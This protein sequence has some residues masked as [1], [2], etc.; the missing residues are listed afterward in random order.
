MFFEFD[1]HGSILLPFFR[2]WDF[3]LV[4]SRRHPV[5]MGPH[6]RVTNVGHYEGPY[7]NQFTSQHTLVLGL[8]DLFIITHCTGTLFI[9]Y[10]KAYSSALL[11][12]LT[13][14]DHLFVVGMALINLNPDNPN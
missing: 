14:L 11:I 1:V 9:H 6:F 4:A 10:L 8:F 2:I 7:G 13:Q 12:A 5:N 3:D